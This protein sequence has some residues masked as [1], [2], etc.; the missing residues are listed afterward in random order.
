MA[1]LA[2][3]EFLRNDFQMVSYRLARFRCS[4]F[5][6]PRFMQWRCEI[7]HTFTRSMQL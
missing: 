4:Q 2:G 5:A 7:L 1:L 3:K 6:P